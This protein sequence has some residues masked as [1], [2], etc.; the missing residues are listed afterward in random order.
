MLSNFL[1]GLREGL[2]ASLVVSILLAYLVKSQRR[3]LARYIWIGVAGAVAVS[4]GFTLLLGLQSRK[5]DHRSQ[6]LLGGVLSLVAVVF[7]TFMI[8][9]MAGA[10]RSIAG[11]LRGRID[12][13]AGSPGALMLI[14][15]VSVGR[16]GMETAAILWA[17]T[18][19]ATGRDQVAGTTTSTTPL[20]GALLGIA[21]A[22]VL[23]YLLYRGA[24][25]IDLGR[26]F[27]VTGALL[28]VVAAGVLAY[29]VHEL[30]EIDLLPGGDAIAWDISGVLSVGS[31]YGSLLAGLFNITPRPSVLEVV[32][33][34][35]Y[36]VPVM[37]LFRRALRAR[38]ARPARPA[39]D[40]ATA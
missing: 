39:P 10:A 30:Q 11:D 9:W 4:V 6:E 21:T 1:I 2:E 36:V 13:A 38:P 17:N 28:V 22:V 37:V 19:T 5:L 33:W 35:A 8:F 26:F 40:A 31:W 12:A 16:E 29:G 32:A 23:G 27:A 18:Q 34:T 24:I 3:H 20:L 14:G 7:V 25:T 15:L